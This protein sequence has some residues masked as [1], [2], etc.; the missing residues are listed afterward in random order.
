MDNADKER[1]DTLEKL[2]D[3]WNSTEVEYIDLDDVL[4]KVPIL[5][6]ILDNSKVFIIEQEVNNEKND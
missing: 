4:K 1:I 2:W 6:P 5:N 3:K